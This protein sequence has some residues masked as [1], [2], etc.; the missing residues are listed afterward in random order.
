MVN[1]INTA[2]SMELTVNEPSILKFNVIERNNKM[3]QGIIIS[4][5]VL[6]NNFIVLS[7]FL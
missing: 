7:N 1:N 2:C 4:N 3:K 6:I 5:V